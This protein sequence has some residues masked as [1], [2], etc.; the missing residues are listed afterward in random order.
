MNP[1]AVVLAAVSSFLL[2][3]ALRLEK[4]APRSEV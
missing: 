2:G 4:P 3:R 1:W